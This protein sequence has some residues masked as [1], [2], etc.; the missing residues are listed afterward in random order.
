MSAFSDYQEYDGLGLA[1]L[2]RKGEVTPKELIES[3]I[4][5]ADA[6]NGAINAIVIE[7]YEDARRAAADGLPEGPFSGVPFLLKNLDVGQAGTRTT[8]GSRMYEDYVAP[9]DSTLVARFKAAG[10]NIF[11]KTNSPEF[12]VLPVTEPELHGPSRNP[13]N[14]GHTTGGSSGGSGAAVAAGI[15][16]VAHASDGGGSIRIPA[17][18]NGLVGLKPTRGVNPIGPDAGEAWGGQVVNHVVSRSVRDTAAVLDATMGPEPG[19]AYCGPHFSGSLLDEVGRDPG[20]LR[21]AVSMEKWSQGEYQPEAVAGLEATVKLLEGLGHTVEEAQP[22]LDFEQLTSASSI[23][24]AVST[25]LLCQM[26][27]EELGVTTDELP[28]EDGTRML[29]TLGALVGATD[30]PRAVQTNHLAGFEMARFHETYDLLLLPTMASEPVPVGYFKGG[31]ENDLIERL[32]AFM[33]ETMLCNQTGQPAISLPLHWSD[34]GLPL[35]MMFSA[36]FGGEP[37]LLRLAGQLEQ[38][39][40]WWDKR[41]PLAG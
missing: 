2:V 26:R 28:M 11:G 6:V 16:P 17:S 40:P 38:A 8:S 41:P 13:W 18:C 30:Y 9:H 25:A 3:A 14:T 20:R 32:G 15:L 21:I 10:F 5:R 33:G 34:N 36:A 27:A 29:L 39:Q 23:I 7:Q 19:N 37:L 24:A 35:G 12:G 1:E 22:N 31:D 4:E